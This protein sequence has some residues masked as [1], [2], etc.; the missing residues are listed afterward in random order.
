MEGHGETGEAWDVVARAKYE[1]EFDAHVERLRA[2]EHNLLEPEVELL[3]PLL[4][5]ARVVNLQCSHGLDALGLLNVGA[6]SVVGIDISAEMIHQARDKAIAVGVEG[7][8]FVHADAVN[9]PADLEETADLIYTGRGS[10]PW[11]LDLGAWADAVR[12]LLRPGG[13]VFVFEGHPL[14]ALWDREAEEPRLRLGVGYFDDKPRE[15]PGFPARVVKR[16]AGEGRPR[17]LERPWRP[18]QVIEALLDRDLALEAFREYPVLFWDQLPE[19]PKE[20][21]ERLPHS[22]AILAR[23]PLARDS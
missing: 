20:V 8:R 4:S 23:R 11:I 3:A 15:A 12:R 16:E 1:A 7:A 18:G 21:R 19:W 13:R 2:G 5:G 6:A 17:M 10:L 14:D 9:P 22:Y